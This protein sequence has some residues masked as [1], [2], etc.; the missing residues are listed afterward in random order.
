MSFDVA[1]IKPNKSEEL[2]SNQPF[3]LKNVGWIRYNPYSHQGNLQLNGR[4]CEESVLDELKN[5][6]LNGGGTIV[7]CTTHGISRKAQFLRDASLQTGVKIIA[8][9]GYYVAASQHSKIHESS[10][11]QLADVMRSEQLEGCLE[12]QDV[13]CGLIG[14][15]GCSFPL[16]STFKIRF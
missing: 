16:H 10:I 14:E 12:A 7:E 13:R 6:H 11:E 15:I 1:Y 9:T 8:G 3:S 2:K 4:D 5:F